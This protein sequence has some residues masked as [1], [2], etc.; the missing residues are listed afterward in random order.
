M[1]NIRQYEKIYI[2]IYPLFERL[3]SLSI[4]GPQNKKYKSENCFSDLA[5]YQI[6]ISSPPSLSFDSTFMK[7]AQCAETNAKKNNFLIFIFRN[8]NQSTVSRTA[9]VRSFLFMSPT[10]PTFAVR[11]TDVSRH[12]GGPIEGPPETPRTSV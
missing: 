12:Q 11:E 1:Q 5:L 4:M 7:D 2:N 3:A 6:T 9:V 8:K 10:V